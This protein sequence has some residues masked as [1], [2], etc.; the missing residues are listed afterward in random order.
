MKMN[1]G[2]IPVLPFKKNK[3]F[4]LAIRIEYKTIQREIKSK[5][6]VSN[7]INGKSA[8]YTAVWDTGATNTGI[9][10]KVFNELGLIPIDKSYIRAVNNISE[11]DI[12]LIDLEFLENLKIK[13]VRAGICQLYDCDV[14]IGMDVIQKGDISISHTGNK[15]L[16]SFAI[17]PFDNPT[18]LYE[19][20]KRVNKNN[21]IEIKK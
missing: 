17:P 18:D 6:I 13:D 12:A 1:G 2:H 4:H 21:K 19:K 14:L 20:A 3:K 7:K 10:H 16:F 5:V 11:S 15:T 9:S 8:E